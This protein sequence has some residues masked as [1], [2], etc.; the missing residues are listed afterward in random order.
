[1]WL[2]LSCGSG[3]DPLA[4]LRPL[5]DGTLTVGTATLRLV[6][7]PADAARTAEGLLRFAGSP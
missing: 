1:M 7:S 6:R 3:P 4:V 5:S 2:A